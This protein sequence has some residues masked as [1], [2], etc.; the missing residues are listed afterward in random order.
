LRDKL[1]QGQPTLGEVAHWL[2]TDYV[3]LQHELVAASKLPENW[4]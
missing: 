3:M 4:A 2:I 1:R